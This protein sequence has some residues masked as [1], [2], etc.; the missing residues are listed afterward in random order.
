VNLSTFREI[1][2]WWRLKYDLHRVCKKFKNKTR[3]AANNL[4]KRNLKMTTTKISTVD[5]NKQKIPDHASDLAVGYLDAQTLSAITSHDI[6]QN[7]G[8]KANVY[9]LH[10]ETVKHVKKTLKGDTSD[11]ETMLITQAKTLDL[12]FNNMVSKAVSSQYLNQ[13]VAYMNIA[14]KAQNQCRKTICA[15]HSIKHPQQQTVIKQQN[16]A[17]NQQVN[18]GEVI[19]KKIK[20][21]NELLS[22]EENHAA[23]DIRRTSKAVSNNQEME[24][25]ATVDRS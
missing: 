13:M 8:L 20:S 24:T 23:L 9:A 3:I 10:T 22:I 17:V 18:N 2:M 14:I 19:E 6:M 12:L 4:F 21:E 11:Q 7:A 16:N 15:L 1:R 5:N 25:V